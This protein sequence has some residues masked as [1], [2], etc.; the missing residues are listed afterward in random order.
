M[1]DDDRHLLELIRH[2]D[3]S[4][5]RTVDG[6]SEAAWAEP[7]LLP[8]WTRGH[9][10]AHLALNAEGLSRVLTGAH[11]G[12]P[13]AMYDSSEARDTDIDELA[14]APVPDVRSR[15][16]ASTTSFRRALTTMREEDWEARF[17]RTPGGPSFA[18]ASIPLMRVREVE[19][20]HADL[21]AGYSADDWPTAF[22]ALLLRSMTKRPYPAPFTAEATDLGRTWS[23]GE[24]GGGPAV[25]GRSADLGWWLT[26]RGPGERLTCDADALPR[27]EAW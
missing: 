7:S 6:L 3:H 20:H 14:T 9:V 23:Y 21:G 1:S 26:G 18:V 13:Q 22:A 10:V 24:G 15:L 25:T 11:L 19:I 12:Q 5:V 16:L 4:L 27:I 2:A 17:E 8:D